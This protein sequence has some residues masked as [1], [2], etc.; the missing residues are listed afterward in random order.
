[1]SVKYLENWKYEINPLK[2]EIES[3]E[4]S[5][6]KKLH[7]FE[8][9]PLKSKNRVNDFKNNIIKSHLQSIS[10][11]EKQIKGFSYDFFLISF[12]FC[13]TFLIF[14]KKILLNE[15]GKNVIFHL[16]TCCLVGLIGGTLFGYNYA[17]SISLYKTYSKALE[18][19]NKLNKDFDYY[20]MTR[21]EEIFEE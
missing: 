2:Y 19:I 8:F 17:K 14:K 21:H 9:S 3:I 7:F 6:R 20:Y 4:L 15:M 12:V 11:L 10:L 16:S 5:L 1:M 18:R 13:H